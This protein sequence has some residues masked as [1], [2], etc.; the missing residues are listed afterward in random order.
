[1]S[2]ESRA[3]S[4]HFVIDVRF[5]R[6]SGRRYCTWSGKEVSTVRDTGVS[7]GHWASSVARS[8]GYC[9]VITDRH[10]EMQLYVT[11]PYSGG[12]APFSAAG[13]GGYS[14]STASR[15]RT[16]MALSEVAGVIVIIIYTPPEGVWRENGRMF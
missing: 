11:L 1:M 5:S 10:G 14:C 6:L 7:L 3:S 13:Y 2:H 9:Y 12:S 15:V 8:F 4:V 16:G